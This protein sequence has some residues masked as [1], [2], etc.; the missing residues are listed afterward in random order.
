MIKVFSKVSD[1]NTYTD[2][3]LNSGTIYYVEENKSSHF[4]TN[5]IDGT[6]KVY[7]MSEGGTAEQEL[8]WIQATPNPDLSYRKTV[9]NLK[10]GNTYRIHITTHNGGTNTQFSLYADFSG[11]IGNY[12]GV[13][14]NATGQCRHMN[15]NLDNGYFDLTIPDWTEIN[16]VDDEIVDI[17]VGVYN[18]RGYDVNMEV[19]FLHS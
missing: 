11:T 4:R 8:K 16:Q 19:A 3:G 13:Y 10:I 2:G 14:D 12:S 1:Y 6:D 7:D 17:L 15:Y 9:D 18:G 5:N